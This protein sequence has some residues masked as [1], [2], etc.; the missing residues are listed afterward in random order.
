MIRII[1]QNLENNLPYLS[2]METNKLIRLD[3]Q[4]AFPGVKFNVRKD[5]FSDC[6]VTWKDG[7][8]EQEV[9]EITNKYQN[10]KYDAKNEQYN[11]FS[12]KIS[13]NGQ[14]QS[15]IGSIRL[16]RFFSEKKKEI[17]WK[18][19]CADRGK[20]FSEIKFGSSEFLYHNP[21]NEK[22]SFQV[23]FNKLAK[24]ISFVNL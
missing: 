11:Y 13:V 8:T 22:Y 2:S 15:G 23:I 17:I 4:K 12:T 10:K 24:E 6:S 7:P 19:L 14:Y 16:G 5:K 20:E 21:K 1:S 18:Q 9:N 3:L